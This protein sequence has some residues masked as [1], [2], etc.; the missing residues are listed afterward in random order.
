MPKARKSKKATKVSN[1]QSRVART[2]QNAGMGSEV[3]AGQNTK[4]AS[5]QPAM[6]NRRF[7]SPRVAGPQSLIMPG[8]VALGC[9]GMAFSFAYFYNDPN[10]MIFAAMAALMAL[11][12]SYSVFA[13]I[14]KMR[15]MR[16]KSM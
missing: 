14:R 5:S 9:W 16:Q 6:A 4:A 11:L 15:A 8:M 1:A 12:W 10:H 3:A 2:P 13:R 7:V